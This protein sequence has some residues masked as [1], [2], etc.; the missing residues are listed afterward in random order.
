MSS[1]SDSF[2]NLCALQILYY[3]CYYYWK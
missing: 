3:Y 2:M 1:A